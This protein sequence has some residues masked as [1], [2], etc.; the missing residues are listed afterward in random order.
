[1]VHG[2]N[3]WWFCGDFKVTKE[4][5]F[6]FGVVSDVAVVL[7]ECF[8]TGKDSKEDAPTLDVTAKSGGSLLITL[9]A[10]D[11]FNS[12]DSLMVVFKKP[13]LAFLLVVVL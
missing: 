11:V 3:F 12:I 1:M 7:V 8:R 9:L 10:G 2:N 13:W 6:D 4:M 5:T